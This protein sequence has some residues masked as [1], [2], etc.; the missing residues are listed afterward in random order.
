MKNKVYQ[1][2]TAVLVGEI[3]YMG[4]TVISR[5]PSFLISTI[6]LKHN[7][8]SHVDM[9]NCTK[10]GGWRGGSQLGLEGTALETVVRRQG[11]RG[12]T[13]LSII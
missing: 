3:G 2:A 5:L 12:I 13:G 4:N 9:F 7:P 11:S 1:H 8:L 6:I 10:Q